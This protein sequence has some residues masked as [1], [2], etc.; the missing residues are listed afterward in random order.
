MRGHNNE[1]LKLIWE[2]KIIR[3]NEA[4]M[5]L[6]FLSETLLL[7]EELNTHLGSNVEG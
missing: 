4:N 5:N 3:I 2:I 6:I 1:V 7:E